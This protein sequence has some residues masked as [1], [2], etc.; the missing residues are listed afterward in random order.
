MG[1]VGET[2]GERRMERPDKRE[3]GIVLKREW[4]QADSGYRDIE[5]SRQPDV[6]F[7]PSLILA[8]KKDEVCSIV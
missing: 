5:L 2:G 8:R 1:A 6:L 3:K 7:C 4:D